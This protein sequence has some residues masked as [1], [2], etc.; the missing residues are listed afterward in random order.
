MLRP[1]LLS[2]LGMLLCLLPGL[3][4]AAQ[5]RVA[6][7]SNFTATLQRLGAQFEA[8]TGHRDQLLISSASTGK[9]FAQ[10]SNGAA[11]DIFLAAD[12]EHPELLEDR[13]FGVRGSRFAYAEGR[14][15]LWVPQADAQ[16]DP[17]DYLTAGRFRRLAIANPRLA[18]YGLAARQV[19]E[20]WRLWDVLQDK[21]VSGENV[22]QTLQFVATGNAEAGFVALAQLRGAHLAP[23]GAR[24]LIPP[25]LHAPISQH[26]LLLRPGRAAE[27]FMDYLRGDAAA[28]I[29]RAAGYRVPERS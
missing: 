17:R 18:P 5:I 1:H 10:I 2:V 9:H 25:E 16:S 4:A 19:L 7:A 28:G 15:V 13:G 14:L 26:A 6:V 21:L 20:S 24:W 8:Q 22:A 27:A 12:A 29:L 11:F 3:T 23:G